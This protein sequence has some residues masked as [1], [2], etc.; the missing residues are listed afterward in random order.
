MIWKYYGCSCD[1]CHKNLKDSFNNRTAVADTEQEI[2]KYAK[3][4]GWI[5]VPQNNNMVYCPK[6][7]K[8][9]NFNRKKQ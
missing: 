4:E 1:N 7:A 9:M 6:C 2:V 3:E 5:W 8:R